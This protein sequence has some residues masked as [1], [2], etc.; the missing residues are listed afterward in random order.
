MLVFFH[1]REDKIWIAIGGLP[2]KVSMLKLGV[3]NQTD[4]ANFEISLNEKQITLMNQKNGQCRDY[5]ETPGISFNNCS[6]NFIK[7]YLRNGTNCTL[8]GN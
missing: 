2:Q 3:H 8:P 7:D 5:D 4:I 1:H 6:K